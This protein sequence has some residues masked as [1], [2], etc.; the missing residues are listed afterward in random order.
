MYSLAIHSEGG[1]WKVALLTIKEKSPQILLLKAL[2]IEEKPIEVLKK[3]LHKKP[4]SIASA[5]SANEII[6]RHLE[7]E[8]KGPDQVFAALPFQIEELI[9]FP[10]EQTIIHPFLETAPHGSHVCLIA[11]KHEYLDAHISFM[12]S[13]GIDPQF[14]TTAIHALK[15]WA[16]FV[17][18]EQ[19][20]VFAV[21]L[22]KEQ[23]F[24]ILVRNKK[25][26][27]FKAFSANNVGDW[28]RVKEYFQSKCLEKEDL[29]WIVAGEPALID[30]TIETI[31]IPDQLQ[32]F[33]LAIGIGLDNLIN[34]EQSVQWRKEGLTS[35]ALQK[36]QSRSLITISSLLICSALFFGPIGHFFLRKH[37]MA[38][39][40]RS[41][42]ALEKIGSPAK[43]MNCNEILALLQLQKS[44][45]EQDKR[46]GALSPSATWFI[47]RFA[48]ACS[49]IDLVKLPSV[50]S[51]RY[52]VNVK[53]ESQL[54]IDCS[55]PD[56][57]SLQAL[58]KGL[59]TLKDIQLTQWKE[60]KLAVS[61][62]FKN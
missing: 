51:L 3:F 6:L 47:S 54:H 1:S 53:G 48:S 35:P 39:L 11:T 61:L 31:S 57:E 5:L 13:K 24:V 52:E 9:P 33:A 62:S 26:V 59:E 16:H 12:R 22:N 32:K 37:D 27:E 60:K 38:L 19:P 17:L 45:L 15:R 50:S 28:H 21:Y 36:N 25:I 56:K 34:D 29:P 2:D 14:I 49:T 43:R 18:P 58:K 44:Q 55:C 46:F 20:S 30:E 8:I 10:K 42:A 41:Q 23:S 40:Q 7:M 4:Y